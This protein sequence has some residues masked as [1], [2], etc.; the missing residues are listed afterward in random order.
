MARRP[1][2]AG[3]ALWR[4]TS[5]EPEI[6]LAHFGGPLWARRD[7][8]AWAIPKGLVDE[9]EDPSDAARREFSEELGLR[10]EG[11]MVPLVRFRQAGGKEVQAFAL[12]GDFDPA[13]LDS[14]MF[15]MEWP[16]RSGRTA[17]FPE[18]DRARWFSLGQAR[19]MILR[20]QRP[21]LDALEALIA[22]DG[23]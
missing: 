8:G 11:D 12:E 1:F 20:S 14:N 21:I 9:D 18:V 5:G 10:P 3:I 15:A 6:L 13:D 23:R 7:A 17:Q 4:W 2:S 16:P 19:E 22:N